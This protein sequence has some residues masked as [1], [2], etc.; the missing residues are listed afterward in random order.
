M[1][2]DRPRRVAKRALAAIAVY[3]AAVTV[4]ACIPIDHYPPPP[5]YDGGADASGDV[6]LPDASVE[7]CA[8]CLAEQCAPEWESCMGDPDC[9]ECQTDPLGEACTRSTHRHALR[10]CACVMPTCLGVCQTLCFKI[11]PVPIP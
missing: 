10:N 1:S 7:E 3:Q 11:V 8:S 2:F 4:E 5:R 9:M 6:T